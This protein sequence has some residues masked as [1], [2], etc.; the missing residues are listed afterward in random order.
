M[1]SVT[2][3][4]CVVDRSVHIRS[5]VTVPSDPLSSIKMDK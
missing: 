5:C 3:G 2:Q 1:D 4:V